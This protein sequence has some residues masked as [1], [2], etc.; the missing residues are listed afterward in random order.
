MILVAGRVLIVAAL[1]LIWEALPRLG[2]VD[3]ALL[4]P[5][6]AV[7]AGMLAMLHHPAIGADLLVSAAEIGAAFA[8][9]VPVGLLLGLALGESR[10]FAQVVDPLVFFLFGIPKSIFL[11]MFI[12]TI[13]I[14]FAQKVAFGMFSAFLLVMISTASA[15]RSVRP[16]HL[17]VARSYGATR[18]QTV[19]RVYLPG[20][21]PILLEGLRTALIFTVTAV[22]LAEVYASR[23]GFGHRLA[24]W[25]ENF[26]MTPLLSGVLLVSIAA[27]LANEALR[28]LEVRAGAWRA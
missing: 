14:G 10:R 12:L 26:D 17:L 7:F 21:L 27:I 19:L 22:M 9:S 18:A 16:E 25:G 2:V 4:P 13:G 24:D 28:W 23:A 20:M 15:V 6:S 1:L 11:P 8:L 5:F 3:P